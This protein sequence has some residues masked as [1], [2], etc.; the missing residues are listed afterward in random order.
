MVLSLRSGAL[1]CV[2]VKVG[3]SRLISRPSFSHFRRP[4]FRILALV[5]PNSW[6]TQNA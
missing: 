2:G 5:W 6:K 3:V 1:Y 4:P